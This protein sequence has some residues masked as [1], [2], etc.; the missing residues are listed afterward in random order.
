M[1]RVRG[2]RLYRLNDSVSDLSLGILSQLTGIF[3]ALGT[4]AAFGWVSAHWSIQQFTGVP[5][6]IARTPFPASGSPLGF[7]LD[8]AALACWSAVFLLDDL[9]Y[10]WLHRLSHEVNV[11][12]AGHVVH[13][14]SEEYNLTV[15]LRQSS[16]HGLM[17]WVF[18]MPLALL[19]VPW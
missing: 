16:L 19:G 10:Y 11:L 9:A 5:D 1:A 6:W 13:H 4:I 18:Y 14:S 2:K 7:G 8:L 15:A 17:G 12:W 3:V